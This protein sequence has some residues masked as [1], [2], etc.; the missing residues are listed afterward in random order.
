M[1]GVV[2]AAVV[3]VN[4]VVA[5]RT[6]PAYQAM[7]PGQQEL[8]RYRMALDPYKRI[9]VAVIGTLL[10]LIAGSSAAGQWRT[11]MQWR[12]GV[13]FGQDDPQFGMDISFFA[14]D[15]PW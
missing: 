2:F 10:G 4:F 5:Y 11:Y 14:F 15:L 7:I 8:D 3:A 13:A 9:V 6:R 1:F 12:N